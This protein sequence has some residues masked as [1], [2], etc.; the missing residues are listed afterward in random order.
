MPNSIGIRCSEACTRSGLAALILAGVALGLL[1]VTDEAV[2]INSLRQYLNLRLALAE[3]INQVEN[4]GCWKSLISKGSGAILSLEEIAKLDCVEASGQGGVSFSV[5]PKKAQDVTTAPSNLASNRPS[6]P[7]SKGST[8]NAVPNTTPPRPPLMPIGL[9]TVTYYDMPQLGLLTEILGNLGNSD[10]LESA[11]DV[12]PRFDH[13]ILR[14]EQFRRKVVLHR[15]RAGGV[16]LIGRWAHAEQKNGDDEGFSWAKL[17]I[18]DV[19]EI[20]RYE[21]PTYDISD[22]MENRRQRVSIP[23][24]PIPMDLRVGATIL[25]GAL[26][27]VAVFF[28]LYQQEARR[29]DTY[30]DP[31]TIFA[32]LHQQKG[33]RLL[34]IVLTLIPLSSAVLLTTKFYSKRLLPNSL[35]QVFLVILLA[36]V[37]LSVVLNSWMPKP[38]VDRPPSALPDNP[39]PTVGDI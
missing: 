36:A 11:R 4:D 15:L 39:G 34:F 38:S 3:T 5:E 19:T 9:K 30:P 7:I 20:A 29:A 18:G 13:G 25:L 27:L 1:P 31:G 22:E 26:L 21:L 32:M 10:L 37:S 23:S 14:W 6:I 33:G 8:Q 28:W 16:A 12:G 24:V 2:R 17:S 35:L